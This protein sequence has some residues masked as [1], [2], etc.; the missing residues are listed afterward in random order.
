MKGSPNLWLGARD[1]NPDTQIQSSLG[2]QANPQDQ[3]L[4]PAK[5]RELRQNPQY[6]RNEDDRFSDH[7]ND[8]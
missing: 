4:S 1:S 3:R 6:S 7:F 8:F 2:L 5:W